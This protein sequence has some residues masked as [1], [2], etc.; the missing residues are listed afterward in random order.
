MKKRIAKKMAKEMKHL[1]KPD[2][3]VPKPSFSKGY[4]IKNYK[5]QAKQMALKRRG[6]HK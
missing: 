3:P 5:H 2:V 4:Y 6:T 1:A